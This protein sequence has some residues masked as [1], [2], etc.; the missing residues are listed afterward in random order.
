MSS[1]VL[2]FRETLKN[3]NEKSFYLELDEEKNLN[4]FRFN[5]N[6]D[7]FIRIYPAVIPKIRTNKG[8]I[9]FVAYNI[10]KKIQQTFTFTRQKTAYLSYPCHKI[11]KYFWDGKVFPS[12]PTIQF[13][14]DQIILNQ[15]TS[16]ILT[17]NYLTT[18]NILS[19][20]SKEEGKILLEAMSEN[21]YGSIVIDYITE[22]K[23][24][25][26]TV[27]DACTRTVIPNASVFLGKEFIGFTDK[28]GNIFLGDLKVG[29][30][31][32][33]KIKAEGYQDTDKDN[34]ANDFFIVEK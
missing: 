5:L 11:L 10:T 23:P 15:E 25:Y 2:N 30:R 9:K 13:L 19:V 17:I 4:K 12:I 34:I 29:Q 6:E 1:V 31:Y 33:L 21:R 7:A 16:G 8:T 28:S 32:D 22:R 14:E 26:L 18:Y 20:N 27:K 3:G 24:V